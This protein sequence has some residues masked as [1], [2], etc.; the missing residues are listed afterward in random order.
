MRLVASATEKEE[1]QRMKAG[2]GKRQG[3][4]EREGTEPEPTHHGGEK[5]KVK[6]PRSTGFLW[7]SRD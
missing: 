5:V 1:R 6:L 7:E 4:S 3:G 2:K